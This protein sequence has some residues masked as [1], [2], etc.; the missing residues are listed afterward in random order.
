MDQTNT[1]YQ[2]KA[3]EFSKVY[4][5]KSSSIERNISN[6]MKY[7][8]NNFTTSLFLSKIINLDSIF[9]VIFFQILL[10]LKNSTISTSNS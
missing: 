5:A 9:S 8:Q 2:I 10:A 1:S 3:I 4:T 6:I 7:D